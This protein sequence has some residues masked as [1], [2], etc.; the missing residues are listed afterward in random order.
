MDKPKT[1]AQ[2]KQTANT[3]AVISLIT[4]AVDLRE[5]SEK[6]DKLAR[7]S[8]Y[9]TLAAAMDVMTQARTDVKSFNQ[10][11]SSEAITVA[12]PKKP[13]YT[14]IVRSVWGNNHPQ[15]KS[16]LRYA[17]VLEYA[18]QC[19][20]SSSE[21]PTWMEQA[22]GVEELLKSA[23]GGKDKKPVDP[24]EII[25]QSDTILSKTK[26][27]LTMGKETKSLPHGYS[28][29]LAKN[30]G[31]QTQILRVLDEDVGFGRHEVAQAVRKAAEFEKNVVEP[32]ASIRRL[33]KMLNG[34]PDH[35]VIVNKPSGIKILQLFLRQ[36]YVR[37]D[38]E[39][40]LK[41]APPPKFIQYY[42][43]NH[44]KAF[45]HG[46]FLTSSKSLK[47]LTKWLTHN[48]T[49]DVT[50]Y[51]NKNGILI[52]D[53]WGKETPII[54]DTIANPETRSANEAFGWDKT[55]PKLKWSFSV[56]PNIAATLDAVFK[57]KNV[58][59]EKKAGNFR[60]EYFCMKGEKGNQI[61]HVS[62]DVPV[63]GRKGKTP[64]PVSTGQFQVDQ[65]PKAN[66]DVLLSMD[67]AHHTSRLSKL[68]N[69]PVTIF[70]NDKMVK[71]IGKGEGGFVTEMKFPTVTVDA[72]GKA[73]RSKCFINTTIQDYL[74]Y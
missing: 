15:I 19:S 64:A 32:F 17:T 54:F 1:K 65:P 49:I 48:D 18:E 50:P 29:L 62:D 74:T 9:K 22:G 8:L 67:V 70:G 11:C 30:N 61:I 73:A 66:F 34:N 68:V 2:K 40:A 24:D 28:V 20:K 33:Q 27:I 39:L 41:D 51:E 13:S 37:L 16:V 23:R 21:L 53:K 58:Q 52:K 72:E 3:T 4:A 59:Q 35:Y 55:L 44:I 12:D 45:P 38:G 60:P 25:A 36:H 46:D 31:K 69:G 42:S 63:R 5:K 26:P 7:T 57:I 56:A 47:Q 6:A 10:F 43:G 14:S 71:I